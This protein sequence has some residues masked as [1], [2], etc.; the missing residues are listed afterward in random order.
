MPGTNKRRPRARDASEVMTQER[1]ELRIIDEDTWREVHDR[2]AAVK[3]R[4][5]KTGKGGGGI[6]RGRTSYLLS[7]ILV[8]AS[9]GAPMSISAGSN[10]AYY[11]CQANRTKG[12]CSNDVSVR[13]DIARTNILAAIRDEL[14]NKEG[15]ATL[16]KTVT[17][18]LADLAKSRVKTKQECADR[19]ART[20]EKIQALIEFVARGDRSDYIRG[21]L[22]DLEASALSDRAELERLERD[23]DLP[24]RLPTDEEVAEIARDVDG[25]LKAE[26]DVGRALLRRCLDGGTIRVGKGP[27][28]PFAAT[29]LLPMVMLSADVRPKTNKPRIANNS[30][31]LSLSSG[32]RL[33]T[34]ISLV[35]FTILGSWM[36]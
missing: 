22:R 14:L 24:I 7:G 20:E 18:Q 26:P 29:D 5:T 15:L 34:F 3:R 21:K 30:R 16:R 4:Y 12:L 10:A 9:C 36:P 11:R 35:L 31:L 2:L 23:A 32:G 27:S 1:P 17:R 33:G 8:C 13:E 28:G 19:L 6:V 25:L